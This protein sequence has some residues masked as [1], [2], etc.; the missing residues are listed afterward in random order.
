ML[1]KIAAALWATHRSRKCHK[2]SIKTRK[3]SVRQLLGMREVQLVLSRI[4]NVLAQKR[5]LQIVEKGNSVF[6]R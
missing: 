1:Q 3:C 5:A 2:L 4:T 6:F